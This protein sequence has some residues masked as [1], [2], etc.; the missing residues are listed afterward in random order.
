[1]RIL[2]P[3]AVMFTLAAC[4][5]GPHHIPFEKVLAGKSFPR[6]STAADCSQRGGTWEDKSESVA[7]ESGSFH[8]CLIPTTDSG[9]SCS[10]SYQCQGLCELAPSQKLEIG[11]P[12]AGRCMATFN[13]G[14]CRSYVHRGRLG[15][16]FCSE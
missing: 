11:D 9:R 10:S 2:F 8:T 12:A 1:M 4:A 6:I 5:T 3:L 7:A 13:Y 15:T 16:V 14:G